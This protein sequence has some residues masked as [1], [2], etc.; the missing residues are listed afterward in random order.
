MKGR[1]AQFAGEDE[2][3]LRSTTQTASVP[4]VQARRSVGRWVTRIGL[5]SFALFAVL[6]IVGLAMESTRWRLFLVGRK[7][8]GDVR[9][10]TWG[11]LVRM[12]GPSSRYDLRPMILEGRSANGAIQNPYTTPDDV[13]QGNKLYRARCAL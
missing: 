9:E 1:L 2:Q 13:D 5:A 10:L 7:L 4:E 12:L 3:Q 6:L 11:E 8:R